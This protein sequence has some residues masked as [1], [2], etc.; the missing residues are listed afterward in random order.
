MVLTP[1][2]K[3]SLEINSFLTG[4]HHGFH[5]GLDTIL[6]GTTHTPF[7]RAEPRSQG[8]IGWFEINKCSN[9]L[10]LSQ[11]NKLVQQLGV[12]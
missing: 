2:G 5:L 4:Q 10:L 1:E 8:L 3:I 6:Q 9:F 7:Y 12:S 11:F